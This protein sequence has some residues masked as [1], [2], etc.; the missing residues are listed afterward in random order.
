MPPKQYLPITLTYIEV[1]NAQNVLTGTIQVSPDPA[2]LG[3]SPTN[4]ATPPHSP[5]IG[6][7][8]LTD[9]GGQ[10]LHWVI[11]HKSGQRSMDLARSH[12][13]LSLEIHDRG[14][15]LGPG[16]SERPRLSGRGGSDGRERPGDPLG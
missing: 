7:Q 2:I 9:D 15:G 4:P 10:D 5:F 3:A 12:Q 13:E 6:V 14:L 8:F 16:K 11:R 1:E